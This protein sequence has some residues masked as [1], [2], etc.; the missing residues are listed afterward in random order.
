MGRGNA[1]GGGRLARRRGGGLLERRRKADRSRVA[2]QPVE[3]GESLEVLEARRG[4]LGLDDVIE[5][6]DPHLQPSDGVFRRPVDQ[7][8]V[9]VLE[10]RRPD[11]QIQV[12][13]VGLQIEHPDACQRLAG[14]VEAEALRV[15]VRADAR[16]QLAECGRQPVKVVSGGAR[17]DVDVAGGSGRPVQPGSVAADDDELDV[18]PLEH[19]QHRLGVERLPRD[20]DRRR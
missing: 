9:A 11:G 20:H 2:G 6:S 8:V 13:V 10:G 19:G 3:L 17:R 7:V 5:C 15:G 14:D 12:T 4:L 18:V 16:A 1:L